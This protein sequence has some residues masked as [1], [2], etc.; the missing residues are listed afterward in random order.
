MA[1]K[2][3]V[4]RKTIRFKKKNMFSVF[5]KWSF[6]E[7]VEINNDDLRAFE[8]H[9]EMYQ[10]SRIAVKIHPEKFEKIENSGNQ[11]FGKSNGSRFLFHPIFK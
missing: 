3:S 10:Q 11:T 7:F 1:G 6:L 4:A 8:K 5:Q 9:T 2:K